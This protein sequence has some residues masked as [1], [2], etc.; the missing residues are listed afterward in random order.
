VTAATEARKLDAPAEALRH[1]EV[2]LR[3]WSAVPEPEQ[4]TDTNEIRLMMRA[5][6]AAGAA[7]DPERS[8]AH[9]RAA[10][11]TV[12]DEA[13]PLTA[14]EVRWMLA[15][16]LI[17]LDRS[18]EAYRVSEDALARLGERPGEPVWAKLMVE[19]AN[20]ALGVVGLP[21]AQEL[22]ERA[23]HAA[24]SLELPASVAEALTTRALIT[25]H[26]GRAQEAEEL[27]QEAASIAETAGAT[28]ARLR[29]H[30]Y[31]ALLRYEHD[32]AVQG[33]ATVDEGLA[34]AEQAGLTWNTFGLE[35]RVLQ[36]LIRATLGDWDGAE[37]AAEVTTGSVSGLVEARV[38]A[39]VVWVAIG[40]GRFAEAEQLLARVARHR[41]ADIQMTLLLALCEAELHLWRDDTEQ[42]VAV[43]DA[44][45]ARLAA[46]GTPM[47][48]MG[49]RL[50]ALALAGLARPASRARAADDAGVLGSTLATDDRLR[51]HAAAVLSAERPGGRLPGPEARAWA[52]VAEAEY[53][54]IYGRDDPAVW[55]GAAELFD[56]GAVYEQARCHWR[57]AGALL[58]RGERD[59]AAAPLRRALQT[60]EQLGAQ[61]L[62]QAA[63]RLADRA[64][65]DA[66]PVSGVDP[67]TPREREVLRQVARGLTNK[68]IGAEL[69][70][71]EKT[72]SVHLSR[73][74]AKLGATGRTEAVSVAYARGLLDPVGA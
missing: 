12:D 6:H 27:Y 3:L 13:D 42:T 71:S 49:V 41:Y 32:R 24:R 18:T 26:Q 67:L 60:A 74:M 16:Q 72:V 2:A 1:L 35:L 55:A 51:D 37:R 5:S 15:R 56:F 68:Q 20:A 66:A 31:C 62:L 44:M 61:P 8:L 58:A 10:N 59:A 33:L 14:G 11:S 69:F 23:E 43:V 73:V 4:V 57:Q 19:Q 52:A 47:A 50:C 29:A 46:D 48:F 9:L 36:V 40:R 7:G 64:G 25:Q 45:L 53:A 17:G 21:A 38:A 22:G 54:R 30:F 65:L 34:I 39:A 63:R 70:I 28:N